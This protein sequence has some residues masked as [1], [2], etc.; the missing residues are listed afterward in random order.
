MADGIKKN[1]DRKKRRWLRSV[2]EILMVLVFVGVVFLILKRHTP[3][4]LE[5]IEKRDIS[6]LEAYITSKGRSGVLVLI[7]LQVIETIS[8]V[9][10]AA[11]VYI[12]AGALYGKLW[13]VVICYGTNLGMNILMFWLAGKMKATV[14]DFSSTERNPKLEKLMKMIRR[15]ERLVFAMCLLPIVPNGMIPIFSSQT[16]MNL[17][18]FLKGFL[19]GSLPTIVMYNWFGDILLSRNYK[20]MLIVLGVILVLVIFAWI[21]RKKLTEKL[22][23]LL[24]KFAEG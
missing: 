18:T 15:P 20:V 12:C 5:L 3:R 8:I 9:L 21:F 11:P 13:G 23:P 22:M 2:L 6:G 19:M 4:I 10:P 7:L 14:D 24:K 1:A 16:G 17:K